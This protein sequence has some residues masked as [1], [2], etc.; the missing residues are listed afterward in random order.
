VD[1]TVYRCKGKKT[2]RKAVNSKHLIVDMLQGVQEIANSYVNQQQETKER[3]DEKARE[4]K[5]LEKR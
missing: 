1:R 4:E 2:A 5:R 3:G